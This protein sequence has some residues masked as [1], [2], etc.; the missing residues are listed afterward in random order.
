MV[1]WYFVFDILSLIFCLWRPSIKPFGSSFSAKIN[2]NSLNVL[3]TFI[4]FSHLITSWFSASYI[5][6]CKRN[7]PEI[8]KCYKQAIIDLK[9]Y[10]KEGIPEFGIPPCDP[11]VIPKLTLEQPQGASVGFNATLTNVTFYGGLD[12]SVKEFKTDLDKGY[13]YMELTFFKLKMLSDYVANGKVLIVSFEG[14]GIARGEFS[15]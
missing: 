7:D 1:F 4:S 6:P 9:P 8:S 15:E 13:F 11:L 10:L 14:E 5:T 3:L 2:H 12:F